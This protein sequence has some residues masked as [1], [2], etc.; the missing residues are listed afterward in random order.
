MAG[1]RTATG[2]RVS[3]E[4]ITLLACFGISVGYN[5]YLI[6]P[7]SILPLVAETF[8]VGA[9]TAGLSISAA[10][11]GWIVAQ[12]PGGVALDRFDARGM[13]VGSVLV[14]AAAGVGGHLAT[15]Y[16]GVLLWR[17]VGGATAVFIFTGGVSVVST[18]FDGPRRGLATS[19]FVAS[20]PVG[21]G[22]AQFAS[23]I[24]AGRLGWETAILL[25]PLL[26]L[27]ALPAFVRV[28][29]EPI[30]NE[31]R[32]D[33][34]AL[35]RA[36]RSRAVLLVSA[37]S[38]CVFAFFVFLNAWM[39]TYGE[40]VLGLSLAVAGAASALVPLSGAVTR[41]LGGWLSD[42]V[43]AR[44]PVVLGSLLLAVPPL[45]LLTRVGS[46][47][48]FGALLAAAGG[49]IQLGIGV[50]YAY[51]RELADAEAAGMSLSI[52]T[53]VSISGSLAAPVA[54]GWLVEAG[55]WGYTFG[56]AGG[57]AALGAVLI[58]LAARAS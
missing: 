23:P 16:P 30:R 27:A 40:S 45:A 10:Y 55:G 31:R 44:W 49:T 6:A 15:T 26:S 5:A 3:S 51:V 57:V 37:A 21:F 47:L 13:L 56:A 34:G 29:R 53:T 54:A 2:S 28:V 11:L 38:G 1:N 39:P 58:G 14:L 41:P 7:A 42:R 17:A 19:L 35:A 48:S 52:L 43:G 4:W 33:R 50:A 32:T 20:A 25:Y 9:A 12:L 18:V 24:A 46:P 36:F 8:D 22:I